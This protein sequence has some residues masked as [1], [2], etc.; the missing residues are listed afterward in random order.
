MP[1]PTASAVHVDQALTNIS[2]AYIQS[3]DS[4]VADRV[5]P[6]VSVDKSSDKYFKYTKDYWFR[7]DAKIRGESSESAG[8]GFGITTDS[9]SC[10]VWALHKDVSDRIRANADPAIDPDADA[11]R[12]VANAMMITKEIE[13]ASAYFTTSKWG[14][15]KVGGTNFTKWSDEGAS[16]PIEDIKDGRL[17]IL[18]NTGFLPN[19][20]TLGIEVYEALKKHPLVLERYK[21]TSAASVTP[22]LL[23]ALF[24]VDE[25]L[26]AKA[27]K[28]TAAEGATFS[29]SFILGKNALLSYAPPSPG[30]MLPSAGYT[31][32]WSGLL[33]GAPGLATSR[34]RMEHLKS[35]RVETEM[36]WDQKLVATDLG[37]FFSAA[38][39]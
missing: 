25:V 30:L 24:D 23:A 37:Y 17:T 26:V 7:S 22:Q 6:V 1:Q 11:A 21:Y 20:L 33:A 36:A 13:W 32:A 39:A 3:A 27:I 31:F 12:F 10:D 4:Y 38:V 9:Y 35:D 28:N 29:G 14:T 34:F 18:Q 5:F 2:T 19:K 15:D 8:S 16:D